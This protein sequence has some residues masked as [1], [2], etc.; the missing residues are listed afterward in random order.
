MRPNPGKPQM[1]PSTH[2][3]MVGRLGSDGVEERRNALTS[4]VQ[5]YSPVLR[6][7]LLFRRGIHRNHV[8]DVLQEFLL[9]KVLEKSILQ[10]AEGGRGRFRTFLATALDRFAIN[11]LRDQNAAKRGANRR[12]SIEEDDADALEEEPLPDVFDVAWARQVL[13]RAIRQMRLKCT[14]S[15]RQDIWGV[16]R[17]RILLP[18]LGRAAPV[19]F[20]E[21]V[22]DYRLRSAAV[23]WSLLITA[24]RM[25]ARSLRSVIG[26][27]D[28]GNAD[29]EDEIND[30]R[31]ILSR[32]VRKNP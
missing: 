11:Y 21:L 4:L 13:G 8:D 10:L 23:A 6:R 5:T 26:A 28:H 14:Q 29:V 1:W 2:W 3:S 24:N 27:Y 30:L 12:R 9:S 31:K 17:G 25:F 22:E 7:H 15:E 32:G 16:F 18:S 19:P 20:E